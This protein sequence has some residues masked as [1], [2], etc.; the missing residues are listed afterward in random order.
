MICIRVW[1]RRGKQEQ[2]K[3]KQHSVYGK[4]YNSVISILETTAGADGKNNSTTFT[5]VKKLS[6]RNSIKDEI[7]KENGTTS[8]HI[9]ISTRQSS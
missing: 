2:I 1:K 7:N 5:R 4:S 3:S 6:N 9:R 8:K